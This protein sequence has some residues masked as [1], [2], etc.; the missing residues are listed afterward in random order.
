VPPPSN[1]PSAQ[2]T[3]QPQLAPQPPAGPEITVQKQTGEGSGDLPKPRSKVSKSRSLRRESR[4]RS[5][6][7]ALMFLMCSAIFLVGVVIVLII[8][9]AT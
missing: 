9:L 7:F 2:P 8:S 4:A 5:S 1:A 6:Y 3:S